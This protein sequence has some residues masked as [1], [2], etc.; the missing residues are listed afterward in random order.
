MPTGI[1]TPATFLIYK[2]T[3]VVILQNPE[4]IAIEIVNQSIAD[5]FKAYFEEFWGISKRFKI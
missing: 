1:K 3:V 2:D 5:S 4:T